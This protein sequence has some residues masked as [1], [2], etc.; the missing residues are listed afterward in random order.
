MTCWSVADYDKMDI[1]IADQTGRPIQLPAAEKKVDFIIPYGYTQ[2][3]INN[4][5]IGLLVSNSNISSDIFQ[6][7]FLLR[8]KVHRFQPTTRRFI[9]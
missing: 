9:S 4:N 8:I 5:T 7:C 3:Y 1:Q 2:L 6:L